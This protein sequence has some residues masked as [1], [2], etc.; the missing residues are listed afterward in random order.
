MS[1]DRSSRF[2]DGDFDING[3]PRERRPK[4]FEDGEELVKHWKLP[5]KPF[6][7]VALEKKKQKKV[8]LLLDTARRAKFVK[9]GNA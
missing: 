8:I 1:R 2:K 7:A 4:P 3:R 5:A 6:H 9:T